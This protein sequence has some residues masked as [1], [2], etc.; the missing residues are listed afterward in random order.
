[1]PA[2][3]Y[4]EAGG[5][6]AY[7]IWHRRSGKDDLALNWAASA[8][9]RRI[10][11]YWHMLPEASQ[12]RKAIW[13]AIDSHTGKRRIDQAFPK[14]IRETTRE[15]EMFIRFK[16][17]STWQ[18]LGSDNYDSLVGSPPVGVVASEWALANPKSWAYLRPILAENGGWAAFITTPRGKN[19]AE[20]MYRSLQ[21]DPAAF[22][23][24]LTALDTGVFT[25]DVLDRERA[26]YIA[27]YG[28]KDGNVLYE[29]EYLCSFEAPVIGAI[30]PKELANAK[31]DNRIGSVPYSP[32]HLVST[33]WDIGWGDSTAI[34]FYQEIGGEFRVIDYYEANGEQFT[35]YLSIL[36]SKG[37]DYDT[38]WLPHDAETNGKYATGKSIAEQGQAN[39]FK[40]RIAPKLSIEDGINQ[41]RQLLKRARIDATKC[42]HGLECLENYRWGWNDRLDEPKREPVHDWSSHGSDAWRYMAVSV[43]D[44]KPKAVQLRYE[45]VPA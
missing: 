20:R 1:M 36:R 6:L 33:A 38:L 22:V 44:I 28:E 16:C 25:K 40:V 24:K 35:F 13:E 10:G 43:K 27:D 19:H 7:L 14:E 3:K 26:A 34:W 9:H 2:W 29:S 37:Y 21:A 17:G 39:G 15:N 30:Y 45:A 31:A 18:V 8:A 32:G 11:T 23:Q 41:S 42:A 12:A 4:L 5:L